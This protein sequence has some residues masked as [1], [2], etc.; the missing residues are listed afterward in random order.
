MDHLL[1]CSDRLRSFISCFGTWRVSQ[2]QKSGPQRANHRFYLFFLASRLTPSQSFTAFTCL[3]SVCCSDSCFS[4]ANNIT[5]GFFFLFLFRRPTRCRLW[6]CFSFYVLLWFLFIFLQRCFRFRLLVF[7][8]FIFFGFLFWLR[9]MQNEVDVD[10][11]ARNVFLMKP[12]NQSS[13]VE[14]RRPARPN[15]DDC[16]A[17]IHSPSTQRAT[18]SSCSLFLPVCQLVSRRIYFM[19]FCRLPF[20]L[21]PQFVFPFSLLFFFLFALFNKSQM[22]ICPCYKQEFCSG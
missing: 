13:R 19:V 10:V 8:F 21:F 5:V 3:R 4:N 9:C 17:A 20:T 16:D 1:R 22:G 14:S 15:K 7:P 12:F 18:P 11:Y 2:P 6:L